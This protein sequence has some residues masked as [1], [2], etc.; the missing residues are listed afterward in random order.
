MDVEFILSGSGPPMSIWM[1]SPRALKMESLSAAYRVDSLIHPPA[2][3]SGISVGRIPIMTMWA[4]PA[5]AL[6]SAAFKLARTSSSSSTAVLAAQRPGRDVEF[7]V[8]GA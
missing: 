2:R 4:P 8:V 6:V 3:C 1:S 7:D 5:L